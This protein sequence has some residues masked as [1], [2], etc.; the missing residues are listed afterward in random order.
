MVKAIDYWFNPFTK[1]L[2]ENNFTHPEISDLIKW[3]HLE[4]VFRPYTIDEVIGIMDEADMEKI[5]IPSFQQRSYQRKDMISE[6]SYEGVAELVATN[7]DRFAGLYG[8]NPFKKMEGVRELERSVK[9]FG[10]K[11]A[12]LHT[13]GFGLAVNDRDYW[14]FYAKCVELD[15]PVV[16]QIGHSAEIMP[17]TLARPILID[18]IAIYFPDLKLVAAHTGWPWVEELTAMAWKHPNVYIGT[19]AHMPKYWDPA[20]INFMKTRGQGKVLFGTDFPVLN[21]KMCIDQVKK[22]EL[23]E[24]IEASLLRDVAVKIFKL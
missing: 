9:E 10:F 18:D 8:I 21:P 4:K 5:L 7:P 23:G 24:K 1:E 11:G 20:L 19:T 12:H 17:S 22:M 14:P 13:Y 3:W 2:S 16:M 15:V 6:A